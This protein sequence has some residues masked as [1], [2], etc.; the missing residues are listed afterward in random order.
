MG[1]HLGLIGPL[2]RSQL[3]IILIQKGHGNSLGVVALVVKDQNL[4]LGRTEDDNLGVGGPTH[5]VQLFV[6]FLAPVTRTVH[7]A[8]NDRTV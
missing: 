1:V 6:E 7:A 3:I 5:A 2:N 8:N 4:A